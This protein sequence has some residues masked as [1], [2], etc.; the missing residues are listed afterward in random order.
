MFFIFTKFN[1]SICCFI[2]HAFGLLSK[3]SLPKPVSKAF[4]YSFFPRTFIVLGSSFR[5]M[6][7][8]KL[9]FV[10]GQRYKVHL[11]MYDIQLS[12]HHLLE[13][14]SF[15]H[16]IGFV[17]LSKISNSFMWG[18]FPDSVL[19]RSYIYLSFCQF[20]LSFHTVLIT[21]DL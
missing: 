3:K 10:Y 18:L 19:F 14:L 17:P 21:R 9:I 7:Q 2:D 12:H 20:W 6:I 8:F 16:W 5:V 4:S 13:R 1:A 15:L 11:F